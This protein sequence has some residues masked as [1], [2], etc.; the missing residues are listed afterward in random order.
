MAKAPPRHKQ[1]I[2]GFANPGGV[3]IVKFMTVFA[4]GDELK[5]PR[6]I[7]GYHKY[8]KGET[9]ICLPIKMTMCILIS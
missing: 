8:A 7:C 2:A 5:V 4:D 3:R 6:R 1:N 9:R